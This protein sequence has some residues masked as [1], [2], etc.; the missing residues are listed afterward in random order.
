VI[1][2]IRAQFSKYFEAIGRFRQ[3]W[4][5]AADQFHR[6]RLAAN[7]ICPPEPENQS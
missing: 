4:N 3:T 7:G 2:Q 6:E 1:L 5:A